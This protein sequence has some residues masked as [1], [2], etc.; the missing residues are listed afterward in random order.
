MGAFVFLR[1][2]FHIVAHL[3]PEGVLALLGHRDLA[4][5]LGVLLGEGE[6]PVMALCLLV[7][8]HQFRQLSTADA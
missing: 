8:S 6:L 5:K 3:E 7:K 1:L 4:G 2:T